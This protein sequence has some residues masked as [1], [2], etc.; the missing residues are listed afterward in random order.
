[1]FQGLTRLCV[2]VTECVS[3]FCVDFYLQTQMYQCGVLWHLLLFLFNYDYT[4]EE[5]GVEKNDDTNQQVRHCVTT[6]HVVSLGLLYVTES[7]I[8]VT[9]LLFVSLCI[10]CAS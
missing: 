3:A 2:V 4:L 5:G 9:S 7:V 6:A 8:S 10:T 1:M